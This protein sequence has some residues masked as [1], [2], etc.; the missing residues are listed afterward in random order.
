MLSSCVPF[1][2]TQALLSNSCSFMR[3]EAVTLL[4][5]NSQ[6]TRSLSIVVI[7]ESKC[8]LHSAY[9][10]FTKSFFS[11]FF[12]NRLRVDLDPLDRQ[13]RIRWDTC[14]VLSYAQCTYTMSKVVH[15]ICLLSMKFQIFSCTGEIQLCSLLGGIQPALAHD[16]DVV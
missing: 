8:N 9:E 2:D 5:L 1:L 13:R 3:G 7:L 16:N 11:E 6:R 15:I 4:V 12:S 14:F 10:I